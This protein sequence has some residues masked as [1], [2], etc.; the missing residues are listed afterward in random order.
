MTRSLLLPLAFLPLLA[1]CVAPRTPAPA[2]APAPTPAPVRPMPAPPPVVDRYQGDWS[3]D[4]L[5]P[6]EWGPVV[7]EMGPGTATSAFTGA[8]GRTLARITCAGSEVIL[9]RDGL[10]AADRA[11]GM[12]VRTSFAQRDLTVRAVLLDAPNSYRLNAILPARDALWD[13]ISYSRG[14]FLIEA[15]GM[16]PLIL[17]T[18]PE[19]A[20]V[21][22]SCR[23]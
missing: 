10:V 15:T 14:R 12:S 16:A 22:E 17:P 13:Q 19:V 4:D 8:A 1:S 23:G 5:T 18:R 11:V 21:I 6:G 7:A 20:R 2:P 3:V 9:S